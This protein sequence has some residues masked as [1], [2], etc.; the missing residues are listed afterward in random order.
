LT[1][2][3]GIIDDA[4]RSYEGQEPEAVRRQK[5]FRQNFSY[6]L[7]SHDLLYL[8]RTVY[9]LLC[10]LEFFQ[11]LWVSRFEHCFTQEL[12]KE[13][14]TGRKLDNLLFRDI[15]CD[16]DQILLLNLFDF[17]RKFYWRFLKFKEA[18]NKF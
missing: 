5:T 11:F 3:L 15:F 7:I 4:T 13:S 14:Q 10:S 16:F 18:L 17:G 9:L 8:K 6:L 1:T 12:C 2:T